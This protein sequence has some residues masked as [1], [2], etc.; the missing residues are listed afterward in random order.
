MSWSHLYHPPISLQ[1]KNAPNPKIVP[2]SPSGMFRRV[3][4]RITLLS[5]FVAV[6]YRRAI[7]LLTIL[8]DGHLASATTG[9]RAMFRRLS[10]FFVLLTLV[11]GCGPS[12]KEK[13]DAAVREVDR[14]QE[15]LDKLRPAY[16]LARQ[17]AAI[18][19]CKEIA[20]VTP[21]ESESAA[22]QGIG[23]ALNQLATPPTDNAKQGDSAKKVA[24][25]RKGDE[26][27]K[28][29]ENLAAT[30]KEL[31]DKQANIAAL[32]APAAK[33][34]EVMSKINTPGTPE[35]KKFEEKLAAM[36]EAKAYERQQKRLERAQHEVEELEKDLP[37]G[38]EKK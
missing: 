12:A 34:K 5:P 28:A 22:I 3:S 18:A 29:I 11:G 2:A 27:D 38:G 26:L 37:G 21:A 24:A 35:A 4:P 10:I 1:E 23:D 32:A 9:D 30:Q 8:A 36:P 14:A 15:Q 17:T 33:A 13:Y 31:A 7:A 6:T 19:V 25:G 20:G 16:D